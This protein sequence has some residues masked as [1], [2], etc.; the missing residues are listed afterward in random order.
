MT[1]EPIVIEGDEEQLA[2]SLPGKGPANSGL[3]GLLRSGK[4]VWV[5][6]AGHSRPSTY[7]TT[8]KREGKRVVTRSFKRDGLDGWY[9][10]VEPR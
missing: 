2:K 6:K 5:P 1:S 7:S 3:V 9:V 4:T 10:W 8:F